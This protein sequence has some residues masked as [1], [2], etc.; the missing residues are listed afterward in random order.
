MKR[1][2]TLILLCDSYPLSAGE[3]FIDDEMR[4]LSPLCQEIIV[5]TQSKS[6]NILLD[7]YIPEN[8]RVETYSVSLTKIQK[9]KG[10]FNILRPFF[11]REI[12][13]CIS[14]YPVSQWLSIFKI[15]YIDAIKA[16]Q[17]SSYLQKYVQEQT[18]FYSYWHDY[19]ALAL[20]LMKNKNKKLKCIA[21]AH[22]WDVFAER[23]NPA[24]LPFKCFIIAQLNQTFSISQAGKSEFLKYGNFQ[25]KITVSR[26][27]KINN[28]KPLLSKSNTETCIVSCSNIIPLKRINKIVDVI[29]NLNINNLTW[30]HFGDG[31]MRN[32][33]EKYATD[34][35]KNVHFEF[36]GVIPNN[37]ILDFYAQ[38]YVNL[39]INLSESEGIP[40]SIMEALSA[41]IPVLATNVGGTSEI[42]NNKNGF[43]V[44]KDF[45]IE[46]VVTIIQNYL[47]LSDKSKNKYREEAY[48][49]WLH[50]YE[51]RRNYSE[52]YQQLIS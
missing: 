17:I 7:R 6:S 31:C 22:G 43:L 45:S 12:L 48:R 1:T 25:N 2:K 18:I 49:F 11:I 24:Y 26:L 4:V 33:I 35:L 13:W 9:I 40:V 5:I 14:R 41:G 29:D 47:S 44:N 39:F 30:I 52:F 10:F 19:K 42:V 38:N 16:K 15:Q 3:F 21:R 34:K 36:R 20:A 46:D 23:Q 28:R 50:N 51:A 27:G 37:E 32:E 8:M